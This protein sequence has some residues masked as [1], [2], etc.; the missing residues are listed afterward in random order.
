VSAAKHYREMRHTFADW[1]Q[2]TVANALR[3]RARSHADKVYID[4]PDHGVSYTYAETLA[5]AEAVAGGLLDGAD[6]DD[7][8]LVFAANSADVLLSWLGASLAGMV[9]VPVNT[10]YSGTFLEHQVRT[11]AP[12]VAVVDAGLA[13]RFEAGNPAYASIE[14]FYVL[15]A[16]E[17]VAAAVA[18]LAAAGFAAAPFAELAGT[19]AEPPEVRAQDLAAIFFTS[20]TTGLSKGVMMSNAQIVFFADQGASLTRL[21][22]DDVYMSVG[23]LF[24]GNGLFLGALPAL[25]AGARYVLREKYSASR[26]IDQI[27]DCGATVTNL[28]GVMMEWTYKQPERPDDADNDLRCIFTVPT[29]SSILPDFKR[30]FGI[31]AFVENYG[32]TEI[33]MPV[34]SPYGVERPPG[35]AGK[36]VDEYFEVRLVDPETDVEVPLGEVGE[37]VARPK[38]PWTICSG[39]CNMPEQTADAQRN[40]W[41]HSGDGLRRDED[42]WFYF[43]DRL[44][45]SI[46]RR[47]ENISSYEVEQAVLGHP[48]ILQCA[49]VAVPAEGEAGEDDLAIFVVARPTTEVSVEVVREWCG[50]RLPAFAV[51]DYIAVIDELP[52]TPSGKVRKVEL[53][54]RAAQLASA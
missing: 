7:R 19:L 38:L 39:Y 48:S 45:D 13:E 49:A 2:W 37:F 44:K 24:H 17:A 15:G 26:W 43:V 29:A 52:L 28:V 22:E 33:S 4:V 10:A 5:Q 6:P 34:M 51:P 8:V 46:R 30:R 12:R 47:G 20:G 1:R 50:E 14:R 23:P 35:A 3:V 31:E 36:L 40:L 25:L 41:F 18:T 16:G 42:G 54:Q 32:M 27:R 11:T 21:G 53:R 9:H